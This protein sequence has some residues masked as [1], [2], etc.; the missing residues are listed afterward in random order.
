MTVG[1]LRVGTDSLSALFSTTVVAGVFLIREVVA[2][3]TI[4][5]RGARFGS[6][7]LSFVL[8][9]GIFIEKIITLKI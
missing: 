2:F 4:C 7:L 9:L 6:S 1:A 3:R 5:R 8:T